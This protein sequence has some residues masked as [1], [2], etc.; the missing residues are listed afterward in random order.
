VSRR[1]RIAILAV[2]IVFLLVFFVFPFVSIVWEGL[3]TDR[4]AVE[5]VLGEARVRHVIWFTLWQATV[6]TALTLA[7]GLPIA[8]VVSRF[9]FRGRAALEALVVVPFV[10]P[11]VVVGMAF[12]GLRGSL[13]AI[14][15]AHV[16][17]NVAVVVLVVGAAWATIDPALEDAAEELGASGW[18]R[19]TRVLLPLARPA[20]V[21]AT[22]L[23]F[24]FTF[25][26]F[27]VILLLGGPGQSTIE[28]EIFQRTS[29]QLDL[30][31]AAVL[32]MVQLVFVGALLTADA[33][34]ASRRPVATTPVEPAPRQPR[35]AGERAFGA[36]VILAALALVVLPLW[37]LVRRSLTGVNG[38]TVANYL[39][40]GEGRRGGV[41]EISPGAAIWTSVR[42]AAVAAVIAL[43]IG[44]LVSIG[45][46]LGA[47]S[48]GVWAIVALPLG[49][50][51]VTLGFGYVVAFDRAPLDLRGSPWLV[52]L[53]QA[54]VALPFVVRIV[55][56]ALAAG[57]S[58][59]GESAAALGASPWRAIRDVT[60]PAS[61]G[62]IRT[63]AVFAFVVALGEFGA[64]AFLARADR[65]T[66]PVAIARL[67]GQPGSASIGQASALAVILLVVTAG[68]AIA[69]GRGRIGSFGR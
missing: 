50:S 58:S 31:A 48:R 45:V 1:A 30:S 21:T 27:G 62:A 2:P 46:A 24:L 42:T 36:V 55:A 32:A 41:F 69:I 6:S 33:V 18:R 49:V 22:T 5:R 53:A 7:I 14:L 29:Q 44:G 4:S 54:L 65:P 67:L 51:A 34:L 57:Q 39:H 68:A 15:A 19:V 64:T 63:A 9:A 26:S 20:I 8:F 37:R 38:L 25:T 59:L 28:V 35:T 10:L 16:F 40:I 11:T 3:A 61:A 47:R 43:A 13:V 56:P 17:F 66:V 12:S 52:P 23:V 60:L